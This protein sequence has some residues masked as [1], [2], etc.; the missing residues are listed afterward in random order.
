MKIEDSF[1][2]AAPPE[3]VWAFI[4]DPTRMMPCVP[5]C[6]SIEALDP[7]RYRAAISM[8]LGPIRTRFN[9]EV[10]IVEQDSPH[11]IVSK[12]RGEEGSKASLLTADNVLALTPLDGGTLIAY[13]SEVSLTGRLGKFGFGMLRKQGEKLGR[14][15][16]ERMRAALEAAPAEA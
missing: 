14:E 8:S 9:V 13:A 5:G 3:R 11:R 6:E 1:T 16:A 2:V 15:F 10:E 7:L 4:T 12:T